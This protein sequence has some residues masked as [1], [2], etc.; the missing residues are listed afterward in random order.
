MKENSVHASS[1]QPKGSNKNVGIWIRVSTEDQAQGESPQ[2]HEHRARAYAESKGWHVSEVYDLAGVSGKSVVEHPE[3]KRMLADVKR[4]HITG[5][6]F[7]KLARLA[8]NTREL[9]DFSDIFRA[10]NADLI[11]LQESIDTSTPA[12]RLFYTMIAAMAQWEREEIA[13]RVKASIG[14]RAKLGK[15]LNGTSPYGYHYKDKQLV[16]HPEQAPIR[17]LAYELFLEHRRKGAVARILNER[18]YRTSANSKWSDMAVARILVDPT[19][20]GVRIYNSTRKVGAWGSE[21]RPENEWITVPVEPI[22][23]E[24]L[25][26]QVNQ[27]LEEQTKLAKRPGKKPTHLFAGLAVCHCGGKMYVPVNTP[28]YVCVR[29]RN[30]IPIADLEGI[31]YDELKAFFTNPEAVAGHLL[32]GQKNLTEKEKLLQIQ[33]NEIAKVREQMKQAQELY[34]A[35]QISVEGFGELY[36]PLEQRLTELQTELPKLEAEIDAMKIDSLSADEVLAEATKLYARWPQM[37]V[38]DKRRITEGILEK[39]VIGPGDAI[40]L[41]LAYLPTSEEMINTQQRLMAGF[42]AAHG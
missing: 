19:A 6:I 18:G 28:K 2:H 20:K 26:N 35:R 22:V 7:S 16:P 12:G 3:A 10:S 25:W 40:E 17:K 37:P 21:A 38:E 11:S 34:F 13:D 36:K 29:C 32:N 5:L 14:V 30:K 23:S 24:T 27:I 39:A 31:F 41:T 8:R 33:K 9:L 1:T 15:P 4:G 42:A